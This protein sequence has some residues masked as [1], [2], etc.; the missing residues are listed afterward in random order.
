MNAYSVDFSA[1]YLDL[2]TR[3]LRDIEIFANHHWIIWLRSVSCRMS[4]AQALCFRSLYSMIRSCMEEIHI[5]VTRTP[6]ITPWLILKY[7]RGAWTY[8]MVALGNR[9]LRLNM[10]FS[11]SSPSWFGYISYAL[12]LSLYICDQVLAAPTTLPTITTSSGT[13]SGSVNLDAEVEFYL[14]IRYAQPPLGSLRFA[15][16][17]PITTPPTG[18][19]DGTNFG[20]ACAQQVRFFFLLATTSN[21]NYGFS[22]YQK[23]SPC[24]TEVHH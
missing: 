21:S 22:P 15:A 16:P 2:V 3:Y 19:Q 1:V 17:V 9:K 24:Y 7:V 10:L 5:D 13:Y 6:L 11:L 20:N 23:R 8:K 4:P 12:T 18:T 14:G